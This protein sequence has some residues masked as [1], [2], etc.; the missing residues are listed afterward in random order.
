MAC[1]KIG[2]PP[3]AEGEEMANG[4]LKPRE[5]ADR[6]GVCVQIVRQHIAAKRLPAINVS[7]GNGRK[8]WRV[9]PS[10]LSAFELRRASLPS[11]RRA[12]V[13]D[14]PLRRVAFV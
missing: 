13:A 10:D 4:L 5:V 9:D 8:T 2:S 14:R 7:A 1:M 12:K 11:V 6:L 3:A